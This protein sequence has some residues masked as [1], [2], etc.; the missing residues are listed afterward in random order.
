MLN[1]EKIIEYPCAM[2]TSGANR[3]KVLFIHMEN[4]EKAMMMYAPHSLAEKI[5]NVKSLNGKMI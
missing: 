5:E 4:I 2:L 3:M 1:S